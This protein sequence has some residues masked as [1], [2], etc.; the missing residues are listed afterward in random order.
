M[1]TRSALTLFEVALSLLIMATVVTTAMAVF[2]TGL[3]VQS[4]VRARIFAVAAFQD[5]LKITSSPKIWRWGSEGRTAADR[6][7]MNA[8][9]WAADADS[10]D[11]SKDTTGFKPLPDA[12]AWRLESDDDDIARHLAEGGRLYYRNDNEHISGLVFAI[13]GAPQQDVMRTLPQMRWPYYDYLIMPYLLGP[14]DANRPFEEPY[15]YNGNAN[16]G[17]FNGDFADKIK[18]G[19]GFDGALVRRFADADA[20]AYGDAFYDDATMETPEIAAF[21]DATHHHISK[22][23]WTSNGGDG[24]EWDEANV[25]GN[26]LLTEPEL[27]AF[28][29]QRAIIALR[30]PTLGSRNQS[31]YDT[32]MAALP[33]M[34]A[35]DGEYRLDPDRVAVLASVLRWHA[36]ACGQISYFASEN[37]GM[38]GRAIPD[39]DARVARFQRAH[40]AALR[41]NR[42]LQLHRPYDFVTVRDITHPLMSDYP[43]LQHDVF[44]V[45]LADPGRGDPVISHAWDYLTAQPIRAYRGESH[46]RAKDAPEMWYR[47]SGNHLTVETFSWTP[48]PNIDVHPGISADPTA[49]AV[50]IASAGTLHQRWNLTNRFQASERCR[51]FVAWQV[52]WQSYQDFERLPGA[53]VEAA[54]LGAQMHNNAGTFDH[55][56]ARRQSAGGWT[57]EHPDGA[58]HFE[59]M[60]W[61][62]D[63]PPRNRNR[64]AWD[65][66]RIDIG[67]Y[68][69]IFGAD[70]NMN[71]RFDEGPIP[72]SQRL[73]A[74]E[75]ARFDFYDPRGLVPLP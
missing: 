9:C 64:Y 14:M 38:A 47:D 63:R 42:Y 54:Q 3:R 34:N 74:K 61:L 6:P 32:F 10:V 31:V 30:E 49:V 8:R 12:I 73:R 22:T 39:P 40:E 41:Y 66:Y 36:F 75:V 11:L 25:D 1:S 48:Q 17:D 24:V 67:R 57:T 16:Q 50:S 46:S 70:R 52:D 60:Y 18:R 13:I 45:A 15:T 59:V 33:D 51:Q 26:G 55:W 27:E 44:G 19:I 35:I 53:T 2:P 56:N 29:T 58:A 71:Y 72:K 62:A 28:R 43:L 7:W 23:I 5:M 65:P 21:G 20:T 68:F 37:T 4:Q 69:A